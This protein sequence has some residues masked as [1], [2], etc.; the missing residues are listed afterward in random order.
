MSA[1]ISKNNIIVTNRGDS[2]K[3]PVQLNIG[4]IV[5]P[6]FYD[7]MKGD[8]VYLGVMEANQKFEDA[9]IK[10]K[11]GHDDYNE[12][13]QYLMIRFTPEDTECL[14]PG[15]YYYEI[16]LFRDGKNVTDGHDAVDTILNRTQFIITD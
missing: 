2:F 12:E 14:V 4:T 11:Y 13:Y 5:N 10:K 7:L 3:F 6:T 8:F 9:I 16:K 15:T 1:T